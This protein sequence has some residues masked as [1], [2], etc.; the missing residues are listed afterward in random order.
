ML[1]GGNAGM[2][3]R[4]YEKYFSYEPLHPIQNQP[5]LKGMEMYNVNG[6]QWNSECIINYS[7]VE[8]PIFML[9]EPHTHPF[10]EYV[11]FIGGN[12]AK[13]R[14]FGAEIEMCMGEEEE[15]YIINSSTVIFLPAGF[16]H[17]P[18]N[19]TKVTKPIV[20]MTVS[21]SKE[22]HQDVFKKK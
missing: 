2:S 4:K 21:L 13:V 14:D 19:V 6:P 11:C 3:T 12:P 9:K 1:Q 8:K 20:L 16:P 22:Y 15:K 18:L 10:P 5:T 7:A 17:C